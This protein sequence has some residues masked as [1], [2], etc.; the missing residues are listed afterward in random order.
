M[1]F[2]S[3]G[4]VRASEREVSLSSPFFF[5]AQPRV[6][7]IYIYIYISREWIYCVPRTTAPLYYVYERKVCV[8]VCL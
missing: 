5:F 6:L 3:S 8:R 1:L 7:G 4:S 2:F